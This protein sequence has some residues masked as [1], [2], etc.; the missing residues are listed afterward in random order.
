M[1]KP[2]AL[3][4]GAALLAG[5]A[6]NASGQPTRPTL[7]FSYSLEGGPLAQSPNLGYY[8]VVDTGYRSAQQ[9]AATPTDAPLVNGPAPLTFP[10][11]DPRSWVPFVRDDETAKLD[12]EPVP[13][14]RTTFTDY[15]VLYAEAGSFVMWQGRRN[16]DGTVN[17]RYRQLQNGREWGQPDEKT[18]QITLPFNQLHLPVGADGTGTTLPDR[19]YANLCVASRGQSGSPP[20]GYVIDRWGQV[21]N[22]SFFLETKPVNRQGFDTVSGV[23]YPANLQGFDPKTVNVVSYTYRVVASE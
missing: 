14:P 6:Y 3:A 22:Q 19:I 16:D 15:F 13:V 7:I 4:L 1:R 20:R 5:C 12:V 10:Y 2:L 21:Q 18:I 23:T 17:D 8:F 9:P 11:P